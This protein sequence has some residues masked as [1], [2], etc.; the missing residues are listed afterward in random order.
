MDP[1]ASKK[2]LYIQ[3]SGWFDT[4]MVDMNLDN[5]FLLKYFQQWAIWWI[6]WADLDGFRGD[7]YPYNEKDP[8]S[9]W[10]KAVMDEYPNFNIVG[11]CWT[12]SIPQLAY[13]QGG[14]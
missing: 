12:A 1:N 6:E 10:C 13:W 3:E 7:T 9:Q 11:E 5:P 14:N 4:S 8:M 2:D